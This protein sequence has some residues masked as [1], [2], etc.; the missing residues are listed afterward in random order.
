MPVVKK[1]KKGNIMVYHVEKKFP[2]DKA[3]AE[4]YANT[5]IRRDQIDLI[6]DH[7]ADVYTADGKLLVKFRKNAL[8]EK[9]YKQF[10]DNVIRFAM[11]T[12]SNRGSA[13]GNMETKDNYKNP[14][15]M[16]N[17]LGYFDKFAPS[18]KIQMKKRGIKISVP[19]RET[20]FLM[21]YPEEYKKCLPMIQEIDRL[22]K[23]HIPE[24]YKL[25]KRKA[26]QTPFHIPK[27]SFTTI[28]TNVNF[29]TTLHTDKGDDED[30]FGNI[31]VIEDGKYTGGETCF[32]QY[33]IGADVRTGD[34][35]FMNV[36]EWHGNLP[37]KFE[38]DAK[39][40]S[41]VCYLR[42]NIWENTKGKTKKFM[43]QHN[44]TVR[45]LRG[46]ADKDMAKVAKKEKSFW[47]GGMVGGEFIFER[48]ISG[49][50]CGCY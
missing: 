19:V 26:D 27:T 6:L 14:K 29:Q 36:H 4:K 8:T 39:R 33:G 18:Q 44:K 23:K 37:M 43:E 49:G 28:T 1:E 12:T 45:K 40:L 50:C 34:V 15:I 38:K 21:D 7:D 20:R 31:T 35:C 41:V 11:N 30:G 3:F 42:R 25:Q 24:M 46:P 5:V 47:G 17:I 13:S 22:Y 2:D 48:Q 10:Y 32:L 16:T 9:N